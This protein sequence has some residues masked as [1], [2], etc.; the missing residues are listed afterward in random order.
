MQAYATRLLI[1]VVIAFVRRGDE[2]W[3]LVRLHSGASGPRT[4]SVRDNR[5]MATPR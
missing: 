1:A 2:V 4:L 5:G 3:C